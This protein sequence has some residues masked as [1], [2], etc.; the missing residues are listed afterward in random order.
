MKKKK[1]EVM[2]CVKNGAII[3][4]YTIRSVTNNVLVLQEPSAAL[5]KPSGEE[6]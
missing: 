1:I 5:Y 4:G 6:D 2:S 3:A